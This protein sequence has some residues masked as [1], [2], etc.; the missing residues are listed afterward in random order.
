MVSYYFT[1]ELFSQAQDSSVLDLLRFPAFPLLPP[2]LKRR[3]RFKSEGKSTATTSKS[4]D[5]ILEVARKQPLN[6]ISFFQKFAPFALD[7][8][9]LVSIQ[10]E[11]NVSPT[12]A[13][14]QATAQ[15]SDERKYLA[16]SE[17]HTLGS[18]ENVLAY[19]AIERFPTTLTTFFELEGSPARDRIYAVFV[20]DLVAC[21]QSIDLPFD[22]TGGGGVETLDNAPWKMTSI[23]RCGNIRTRWIG[24]MP[25]IGERFGVLQ[26]V[27]LGSP[28]LCAGLQATLGEA[29]AL[30]P[31][32]A[33][34]SILRLPEA[35]VESPDVIAA[36]APWLVPT[37]ETT[38]NKKS[39]PYV[40][41]RRGLSS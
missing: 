32:N 41:Q 27:M 8:L 3:L 4:I 20:P 30:T 25:L 37:D 5:H 9:N 40:P 28:A 22:V 2:D 18:R 7:D 12:S 38:A 34:L 1:L 33:R 15:W 16:N 14:W 10:Q 21:L 26:P 35:W 36:A 19:N 13:V 17:Y 11:M 23:P 6:E 29:A 24:A 31:I 39:P